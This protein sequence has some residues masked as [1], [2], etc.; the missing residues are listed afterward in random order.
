VIADNKIILTYSILLL[1]C[2]CY[3]NIIEE[4]LE[5]KEEKGLVSAYVCISSR[6]SEGTIK[7]MNVKT[8]KVHSVFVF[9]LTVLPRLLHI[10]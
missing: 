7:E 10:T 2:F 5:S 1:F 3:Y 9:Q 8:G 4:V 6:Y